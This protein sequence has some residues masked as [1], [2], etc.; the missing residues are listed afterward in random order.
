[1]SDKEL[2]HALTLYIR[3]QFAKML[4]L[5]P[6][7]RRSQ[8]PIENQFFIQFF[9]K[10]LLP[11][12]KI[13]FFSLWR[14]IRDGS[15]GIDEAIT[16]LPQRDMRIAEMKQRMQNC[17]TRQTM[18]VKLGLGFDLIPGANRL[19][20][21]IPAKAKSIGAPRYPIPIQLRIYYITAVAFSYFI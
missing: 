10:M 12:S 16:L 3:Y 8:L 4:T 7:H 9:S 6:D 13:K 17:M 2:N 20:F 18:R 5:L 14:M 15:L 11:Q 19:N 1:M 21:S